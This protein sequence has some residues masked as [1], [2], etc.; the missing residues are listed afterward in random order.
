MYQ[1]GKMHGWVNT[2][3]FLEK[4]AHFC[5]G[6]EIIPT[7]RTEH[8]P[9]IHKQTNRGHEKDKMCAFTHRL[10]QKMLPGRPSVKD[11]EQVLKTS[12]PEKMPSN[13]SVFEECS[14]K[15]NLAER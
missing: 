15:R 6:S 12:I 5:T 4:S 2:F 3:W 1:I 13:S 8:L 14:P 7:G 11:E 10:L 9:L